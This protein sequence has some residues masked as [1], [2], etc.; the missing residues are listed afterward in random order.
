MYNTKNILDYSSILKRSSCLLSEN[1]NDRSK[2]VERIIESIISDI[3]KAKKITTL[4]EQNTRSLITEMSNSKMA[5]KY[6]DYA[7]SIIEYYN[8]YDQRKA[9]NLV[10]EVVTSVIPYIENMDTIYEALNTRHEGIFDTQRATLNESIN[11]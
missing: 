2:H 5:S 1:D 11:Y 9:N 10:N 8:D 3:E 6:Y 4:C 7:L